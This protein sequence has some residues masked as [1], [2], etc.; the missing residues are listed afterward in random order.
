M[1]DPSPIPGVLIALNLNNGGRAARIL[2]AESGGAISPIH[3]MQ[4]TTVHDSNLILPPK[5]MIERVFS[6]PDVARAI[7]ESHMRA[8][9]KFIDA[10]GG[11]CAFFEEDAYICKETQPVFRERLVGALSEAHVD[12]VDIL[13]LGCFSTAYFEFSFYMFGWMDLNR[14]STSSNMEYTML[15]RVAAGLHAYVLSRA[16]AIKLYNYMTKNWWRNIYLDK[17]ISTISQR[18]FKQCKVRALST[19][20]KLM[21]QTSTETNSLKSS[22]ASGFMQAPIFVT[23]VLSRGYY[24]DTCV[25]LNYTL[26]FCFCYLFGCKGLAITSVTVGTA[27]MGIVF[28]VLLP[29]IN[30]ARII[31]TVV[32]AIYTPDILAALHSGSFAQMVHVVFH[33]ILLLGPMFLSVLDKINN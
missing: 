6:V 12:D 28:A 19:S 24:V 7:A 20:P 4:A 10:G 33:L 13:Y 30:T 2:E 5:T 9:K 25:S 11:Y 21:G 18:S 1:N 26:K 15:P 8:W 32:F 17:H 27:I 31:T 29:T 22:S 14:R 16:G 23:E 3:V